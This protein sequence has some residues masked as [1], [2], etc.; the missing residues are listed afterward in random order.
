MPADSTFAAPTSALV[1]ALLASL[2]VNVLQY[3]TRPNIVEASA[4]LGQQVQM[5]RRLSS[6]SSSSTNSGDVVSSVNPMLDCA[7]VACPRQFTPSPP[8]VTGASTMV[9]YFADTRFYLH[10]PRSMLELTQLFYGSSARLGEPYLDFTNPFHRKPNLNYQWTQLTDEKLEQAWAL[11]PYRGRRARLVVEV[12]SFLGRSSVRIAQWLKRREAAAAAAGEAASVVPL[13]CID[14]WLGDLGMLLGQIY[15]EEMGRR[16]GHSTLYHVWLSNMIAMNLTERVLPLVAPSLLGARALEFLRLAA[17]V[18][19]L[20]SAHEQRETFMELTS[21]WP[22]V[23]PGGLLIGDDFNWKA[24]SHD[25]QLFA[26]TH[27]LTVRSFD[28]CHERL[29]DPK[30]GGLCVWYLQK[31]TSERFR[32]QIERRPKLRDWRSQPQMR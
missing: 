29:R 4:H 26:R 14:T 20:D 19:Y 23:R 11:L 18:I 1:V 24:V 6:S 12:G 27:N 10:P 21:F 17:D 31:P 15:P 5:H 13:L 7:S 8:I 16:F 32:G 30:G 9:P 2:C 22:L 25:T 28:G 3:I